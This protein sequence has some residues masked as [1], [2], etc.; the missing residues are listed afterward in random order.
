MMIFDFRNPFFLYSVIP[1]ESISI[2]AVTLGFADGTG[3][4]HD[5]PNYIVYT[6]ITHIND[7][8]IYPDTFG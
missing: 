1:D 7:S 3:T 2:S 4:S 6:I 5:S 8:I